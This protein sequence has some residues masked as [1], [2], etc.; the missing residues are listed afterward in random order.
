[1]K[2]IIILSFLFLTNCGYG[3]LDYVKENAEQRWKEYGFEVVGYDGYEM[4]LVIPFTTFG[5]ANV[6][7]RLKKEGSDIVFSGSLRRWG[8]ELHIYNLTAIDAIQP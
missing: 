6:W 7:Y 1:M 5:G 2:I 8:N 4:G 3:N